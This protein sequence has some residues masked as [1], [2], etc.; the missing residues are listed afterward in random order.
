[1]RVH[2][3]SNDTGTTPS[4]ANLR[5]TFDST[6]VTP[7]AD[8]PGEGIYGISSNDGYTV[9]KSAVEGTAPNNN[10][11]LFIACPENTGMTPELCLVEFTVVQAGQF[12]I[13]L[14]ADPGHAMPFLNVTINEIAV[15]PFIEV[16]S[17]EVT[18][19]NFDDTATQDLEA[20]T[21]VSDW[22]VFEY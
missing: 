17:T 1:M 15:V 10:V 3:S 13:G 4:G 22:A 11:D 8:D 6:F 20:V 12:S 21:T 5:L 18:P 14:E 16:V 7:V 19:L 2:T 9:A